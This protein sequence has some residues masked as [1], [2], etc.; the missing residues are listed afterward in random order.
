MAGVAAKIVQNFAKNSVLKIAQ[1]NS[2]RM[3]APATPHPFLSGVHAPVAAEVTETDLKVTGAIPIE[4]CGLYVRNGP[5]PMAANPA[6]YHWFT[7]DAMVHGVRLS[8]GQA[9]WYKNRWLRSNAVS[10]ALGEAQAPGPRSP[11]F[12]TANTNIVGHA[13]RIWGIVEA[14]AYPVEVSPDLD[15]VAHNPFGG[16]L[17]N[18]FS[19]HPH[20]DPDSGE[21]H[22]ITYK[23]G[24]TNTLYHVV[25]TAEGVVR[26]EEPIAVQ[27]G[28]LVH[29]CMITPNYVII[30]DL[31]VTFSVGT[32]MRGHMF[33]FSW[34]PAHKARVGLMPREGRNADIIWCDVAPCAVFHPVNAYET[35]DGHVILDVC[36]HDSMFT[37]STSGPDSRTCPLERWTIDPQQKQVARRVID[38]APQEFPRPDERYI[39]KIYRYA[40]TVALSFGP[41]GDL[42]HDTPDTRI[43]AHDLVAGSRQ[44]HDFGP[45]CYPGEFVFVPRSRAAAEGDGWLLG[46][47]VNVEQDNSDF[48]I[49]DAQNISASPVATVHIPHRIPTGFHGNWVADA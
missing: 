28:P 13:G 27:H 15:T 42:F 44:E 7:G 19:A 47:V 16:T 14:G 32:L 10:A 9:L 21:M 45:G 39:G 33:P 6:N 30:L 5:N 37:R 12:D 11:L 35:A 3:K 49:L 22:A 48:V 1:Y 8:G 18:G 38:A 46:Y 2:K 41:A 17:A 36:A 43:Y 23:M 31:P 25:V 34:N 29:D 40:F 4:L 26:R 24:D 20:T